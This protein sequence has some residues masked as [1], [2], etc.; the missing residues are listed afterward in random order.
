MPQEVGCCTKYFLFSFNI[1]FWIIGLCLLGAGIW[2]WSEKGFFDNLTAISS[3][4]I[5]P[6]LVV[7]IIALVMFL[8]SFSG[9][10]GSLR[11]NIFLLKCLKCCGGDTGV[12]D[13]D[14]NIYFDCA[15][16]ISFNDVFLKPAESCGVPFSCCIKL[17]TSNV[18]NTQCGYGLRDPGVTASEQVTK[19]YTSGCITQ[20][21]DWLKTNLYTVAGVF[22]GV[23]LIQ[24]VPI[25]FAQNLISD[26]QA[27]K[28]GW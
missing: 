23:A 19:I 24:I 3:L 1:L 7:I 18:V 14:N 9:C 16:N 28:A 15:S 22:I 10:L 27:V 25:C 21:G 13:W 5:D 12:A 26:I 8:L 20:F 4:P 6:V 11:E 17:G 2:A